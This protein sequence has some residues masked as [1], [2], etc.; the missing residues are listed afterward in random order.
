MSDRD[1]TCGDG[2]GRE[3]LGSSKDMFRARLK[4]E[5]FFSVPSRRRARGGF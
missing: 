4:S 3:R 1:S 5:R 2:A